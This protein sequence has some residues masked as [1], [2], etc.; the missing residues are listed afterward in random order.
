MDAVFF[1]DG[2][3][4]DQQPMLIG[5]MNH[6]FW[7]S[8]VVFDG[9]R[10]MGGLVPDVEEHCARLITS[11][12]NMLLVPNMEAGEIAE[13]CLD[14]V[15]KLSKDGVYYIRPMYYAREGFLLPEPDSTDFVLAIYDAPLPPEGPFKVCMS[16]RRRPARDMAPTTAKASCLYP[17]TALA[18]TDAAKRGF[19][20]AVV[21]DPNGNVAEF[22]S[23]NLWI[24]K[25][26]VAFTPAIN[27]TFLN[28]VTRQRTIELLRADGIEVIEGTLTVA[29]VMGADEIFSSGNHA[30]IRPVTQFED[31]E[32]QPGPIGR[33]AKELYFEYAQGFSVF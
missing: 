6:A 14:G 30:K 15:R 20:S 17:N 18:L 24:V 1:H 10:A 19:D 3:W 22:L 21:L 2:K 25:D 11:A 26:G 7:M 5:P 29:D 9:A 23:A 31:R 33:R 28:G 32:L 12:E 4:L 27:G 13:L 16:S 8:S